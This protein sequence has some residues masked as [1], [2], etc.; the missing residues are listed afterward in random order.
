MSKNFELLQQVEQA[1]EPERVLVTPEPQPSGT[2][3]ASVASLATN[4]S[5]TPL[6]E[7]DDLSREEIK[8]LVQRLFLLPG[9]ARRVVFAGVDRGTGCSWMTARAA[10]VLATQNGGSV[11][12]VDANFR[13]PTL[14]DVFSAENHY[15]LTDALS[16]PG[17]V[18]DFTTR[19]RSNLW[20][21]SSG[22]R[23]P[24]GQAMLNSE[25]LRERLTELDNQFDYILIDTPAITACTDSLAIGHLTDGI[26][27]V[28]EAEVTRRE[29]ARKAAQELESANVRLLGLVLNKRTFPIPKMLYKRL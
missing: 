17:P 14:H 25:L 16:Q 24:K 11:C 6:L 2:T 26:A 19:L 22:S 15:G 23:S 1:R 9:A 4:E 18:T 3:P 5:R 27:L 21:L 28:L 20:L 29:T 12:V 7:A 8:K 13:G 10:E